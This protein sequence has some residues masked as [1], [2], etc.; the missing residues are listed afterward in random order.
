VGRHFKP[1][2]WTLLAAALSA[3]CVPPSSPSGSGTPPALPEPPQTPA[4]PALEP[5]SPSN[6]IVLG[7]PD[8]GRPV[9]AAAALRP[10]KVRAGEIVTFVVQIRTAPGWHIYAA[11][12]PAGAALPTTLKLTLPDGIEPE[13]AWTYPDAVAGPDGAG[14]VYEG[15]LTFRRQLRVGPRAAPGPFRVTC[16][17]R[18]QACDPFSCKPPAALALAAGAEVIPNP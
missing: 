1:L 14:R 3:G 5:R 11:D 17:L 12:E 13:G 15:Q 7:E 9:T 6:E 2:S 8:A 4:G 10:G 16:D 18:Y